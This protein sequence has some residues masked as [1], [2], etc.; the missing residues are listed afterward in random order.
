M[1]GRRRLAP[2]RRTFAGGP[3]RGRWLKV[4]L[5]KAGGSNAARRPDLSDCRKGRTIPRRA[6]RSK[7]EFAEVRARGCAGGGGGKKGR[8]M[9]R[10]SGQMPR[11]SAKCR[12]WMGKCGVWRGQKRVCAGGDGPRR[13]KDGRA[14]AGWR[15]AAISGFIMK[16]GVSRPHGLAR[17]GRAG[18]DSGLF[19]FLSSF[20]SLRFPLFVSPFSFH[21][22]GFTLSPSSDL[23]THHP[24]ILN[25]CDDC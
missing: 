5:T 10:L 7:H 11:L 4:V 21:S 1:R 22:P 23:L 25:A 19:V 2:E 13:G 9:R 3:V 24:F 16:N 6:R 12:V 14:A 18:A 8:Q 15:L 20:R 17:R